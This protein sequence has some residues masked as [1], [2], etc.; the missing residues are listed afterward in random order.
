MLGERDEQVGRAGEGDLHEHDVEAFEGVAA[1]I[2]IEKRL[3]RRQ[4]P[5]EPKVDPGTAAELL[6]PLRD[7]RLALLVGRDVGGHVRR[8][9]ERPCPVPGR[10]LAE[11]EPL[12]HRLRAVVT[13]GND[14]AVEVDEPA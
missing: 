8:R 6:D 7:E 5:A 2:E 14:V 13:G 1:R 10:R 4:L 12:V 11:R 9:E 3:D